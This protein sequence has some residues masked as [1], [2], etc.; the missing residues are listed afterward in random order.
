VRQIAAAFEANDAPV[1]SE[2]ICTKLDMPAEFGEKILAHLVRR[3]L[4][5][6]TSDPKVGFVLARDAAN[7]RLSD[8]AAAVAEVGFAQST[9]DQ[10]ASL[11]QIAQSHRNVLSQYSLKQVL[12]GE[13]SV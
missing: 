1:S 8:I 4:L 10:P 6:K 3:G 7:I 12:K 9:T 5:I 11:E 13:Q 2:V